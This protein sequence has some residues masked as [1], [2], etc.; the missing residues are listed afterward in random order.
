MKP[1]GQAVR[2]FVNYHLRIDR[3]IKI[4]CR[5]RPKIHLHRW[6][7]TVS[8][9]RKVSV[10]AAAAILGLRR[11]AI[12]ADA[13]TGEVRSLEISRGFC[14]SQFIHLVVIPIHDIE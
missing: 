13:L 14:E 3:P 9:G 1:I 10:V 11:Y 8:R 7:R 4:R 5:S 6:P 2:M 12:V